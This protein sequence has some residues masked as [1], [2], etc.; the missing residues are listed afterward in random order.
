[1]PRS[2]RRSL[3]LIAVV[4]VLVA[5]CG[6]RAAEAPAEDPAAVEHV[7]GSAVARVTLTDDAVERIGI[8]TVPVTAGPAGRTVVPVATVLYD[9]SGQA[10]VYTNPEGHVYVRAPISIVDIQSGS[11]VLSAGPASDTPVVTV[12]AAEL[13]GTELGVGDPE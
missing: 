13:Y 10:W 11:V 5:G 6:P 7:E 3:S 2:L 12:G 9:A 4:G 8:E 1:M